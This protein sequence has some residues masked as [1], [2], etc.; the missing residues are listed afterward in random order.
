MPPDTARIARACLAK[1]PAQRPTSAALAAALRGGPSGTMALTALTMNLTGPQ[2][3]AT[4]A[5]PYPGPGPLRP[6]R[7]RAPWV[8]GVAGVVVALVTASLIGMARQGSGGVG[9]PVASSPVALSAAPATPASTAD[10]DTP[11]ARYVARRGS[12]VKARDVVERSDPHTIGAFT[13]GNTRFA[14]GVRNMS[15]AAQAVT[16][17]RAARRLHRR[18]ARNPRCNR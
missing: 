16:A 5:L 6:D 4:A 3:T 17:G 15:Y 8:I 2:P 10:P 14:D 13:T 18:G 7:R 9:S 12:F 1:D 11:Q